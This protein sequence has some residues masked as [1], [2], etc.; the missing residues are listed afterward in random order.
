MADQQL[1][2]TSNT[3]PTVGQ[4]PAAAQALAQMTAQIEAAK[5]TAELSKFLN[6]YAKA[7][8]A[9]GVSTKEIQET[10]SRAKLGTDELGKSVDLYRTSLVKL[11]AMNPAQLFGKLGDHLVGLAEAG[12]AALTLEGI[13]KVLNVLDKAASTL[14]QTLFVAATQTRTL[15]GTGGIGGLFGNIKF[16]RGGEET[17][18][19]VDAAYKRLLG[20]GLSEDAASGAVRAAYTRLPSNLRPGEQAGV[21]VAAGALGSRGID[22]DTATDFLVNT[23][24]RTGAT[25]ETLEKV[26]EQV[27]ASSAKT[28]LSAQE[29][30][31]AFN[32][33]WDETRLYGGTIKSAQE[34]LMTFGDALKQQRVT[35]SQIAGVENSARYMQSGQILGLVSL[36]RRYG[37]KGIEEFAGN[38]TT[39]S[40][41][42]AS[43]VKHREGMTAGKFAD[44]ISGVTDQL[45]NGMPG[46]FV[47]NKKML[48]DMF[49][50]LFSISEQSLQQMSGSGYY[51]SSVPV[52][53][54]ETRPRGKKSTAEAFGQMAEEMRGATKTFGF[55]NNAEIFVRQATFALAGSSPAI[56]IPTRLLQTS[57]K[58]PAAAHQAVQH[59]INV[60]VHGAG[61]AL[62][63]PK[64]IAAAVL[65]AAQ[66]LQGK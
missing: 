29:G 26:F 19:A 5:T 4:S 21:A 12:A 17:K 9:A 8:K 28:H 62:E 16:S 27:S 57:L 22:I 60:T 63:L 13:V 53:G 61:D 1:P 24:R 18:G 43:F 40:G 15:A 11:A 54:S 58:T 14:N 56:D 49:S 47:G 41:I 64:K 38:E 33:L 50:P 52:P 44:L 23:I 3:N 51:G 48:V 30:F 6:D 42:L 25:G 45:A 39:P 36:A 55:V 32:Q 35:T 37:V 66:K 2:P 20:F 7:A 46:Q 34:D 10:M 65:S 31:K 59:V